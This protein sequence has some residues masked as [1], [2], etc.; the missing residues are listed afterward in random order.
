MFKVTRERNGLRE[1]E[2]ETE[3]ERERCNRERWDAAK[4]I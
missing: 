3:K 4:V 2:R 1:K